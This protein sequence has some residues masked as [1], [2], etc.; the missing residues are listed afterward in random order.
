MVLPANLLTELDEI[1][2]IDWRKVAQRDAGVAERC[3]TSLPFARHPDRWRRA[4]LANSTDE[5]TIA[6][7]RCGRPIDEEARRP[8]ATEHGHVGCAPIEPT[9]AAAYPGPGCADDSREGGISMAEAVEQRKASGRGRA[10]GGT[11]RRIS[12]RTCVSAGD[13]EISG[14]RRARCPRCG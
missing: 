1:E 3:V 11:V 8:E 13:S 14:L 5:T 4:H 2:L 6:P 9:R 7:S 12:G 10:S